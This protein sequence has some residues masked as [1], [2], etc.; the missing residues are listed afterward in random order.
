MNVKWWP[1][2]ALL[3]WSLA[4]CGGNG[5]TAPGTEACTPVVPLPEFES[6]DTVQTQSGLRYIEARIGTGEVVQT[7]D[8]VAVQYVGC[9]TDDREFDSGGFRLEAGTGRIVPGGARVIPGFAEGLVGMRIGGVRRLI[10]PPALGYGD[11]PVRD[12]QGVLRIPANSTLIFDIE[13]P[14]DAN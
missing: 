8:T 2:A 1:A 4:A 6:R 10:I 7:G 13:L 5:V 9:L 12:S 11:Q 3:G 14:A